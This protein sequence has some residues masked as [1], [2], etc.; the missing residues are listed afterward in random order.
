MTRTRVTIV[1]L[2]VCIFSLATIIPFA[3]VHN[4]FPETI[5]NVS[6]TDIWYVQRGEGTVII[7][8]LSIREN[9]Y[10]QDD[11]QALN[12]GAEHLANNGIQFALGQGNLVLAAHNYNDSKSRF[13]RLQE[14]SNQDYP[15]LVCNKKGSDS[16][17]NGTIIFIANSKNIFV[18][19]VDDQKTVK[20][21]DTNVLDQSNLNELTLITCLFPSD[22]YRIITH[23]KQIHAYTW[24]KTPQSI[25]S[26][27][28][29]R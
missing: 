25:K 18:Y 9:I 14:N 16:W 2:M 21:D 17:L 26:Q 8:Q 11:Q 13:S 7:P 23:A 5:R 24:E 6:A 3:T 12:K 10:S 20:A 1:S 15:Y 4:E 27:V 29:G 19:Q 28:L 22:Q